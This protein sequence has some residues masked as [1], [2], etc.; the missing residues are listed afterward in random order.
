[1][2]ELAA[3]LILAYLLGAIPSGL[4]VGRLLGTRD[5][6]DHGSG[7][8][9]ATNVLRVQGWRA[10]LG[11]AV[12]DVAKGWIATALLPRIGTDSVYASAGW[13]A[14]AAG[15]AAVLGHVWPLPARFRGGKGVATTGGAVLAASPAAFA[16]SVLL[17]AVSLTLTRRVS[18]ASLIATTSLPVT[19]P[20]LVPGGSIAP[21]AFGLA[22]LA[23][24]VFTH[25]SNVRNLI[26]GAEPRVG[27]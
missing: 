12:L 20:L 1:L 19:L 21:L 4:L 17:F 8:S 3:I 24:I 22:A 25:R 27:R 26:A 5:V 6:R 13:V 10:A 15:F 11:V 18:A 9:G 2:A 7:S 14:F 23:L 16:V